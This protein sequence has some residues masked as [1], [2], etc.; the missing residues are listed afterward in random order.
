MGRIISPI[1]YYVNRKTVICFCF[2]RKNKINAIILLLLLIVN[3]PCNRN[4]VRDNKIIKENKRIIYE[5][6][7]F[8]FLSAV[9]SRSV[10]VTGEHGRLL[11]SGRNCCRQRCCCRSTDPCTA[12]C[13]TGSCCNTSDICSCKCSFIIAVSNISLVISYNTGCLTG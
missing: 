11:L 4:S 8:T 10:T 1:S 9:G 2:L 3:R 6:T 7:D 12:F 5:K 13:H